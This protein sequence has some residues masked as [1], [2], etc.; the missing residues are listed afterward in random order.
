LPL[1]IFLP[2]SVLCASAILFRY[3]TI[4][5]V[6]QGIGWALCIL[7]IGGFGSGLAESFAWSG[8]VFLFIASA[9]LLILIQ[10]AVVRRQMRRAKRSQANSRS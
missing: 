9:G 4:N 10:D 1:W 2:I 7:A 3:Y 5:R 8:F 6:A